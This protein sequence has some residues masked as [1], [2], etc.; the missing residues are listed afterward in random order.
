MCIRALFLSSS[1]LFIV[2]CQP[3]SEGAGGGDVSGGAPAPNPAAQW[4]PRVLAVEG[5][6]DAA[7]YVQTG[8][9]TTRV[10][11]DAAAGHDHAGGEAGARVAVESAV[12]S[13]ACAYARG[14][15]AS[16]ERGEPVLI[17][18]P[19]PISGPDAAAPAA[20]D[21]DGGADA[22]EDA[23]SEGTEE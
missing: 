13:Y 19:A 3:P 16:C 20:D 17:T 8:P 10:V 14:R 6:C 12:G 22:N 4:M 2:A 1:L 23:P 5:T 9:L 7:L 18:A 15:E 21:T 11:V